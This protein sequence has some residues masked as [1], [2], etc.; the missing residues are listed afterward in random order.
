MALTSYTGLLASLAGWLMRDDLTAV[1]PDFVALAEANMNRR[2]RLRTMMKRTTTPM[3]EAY[4]L[5]PP[6]FLEMWRL[7][8]DGTELRYVSTALL[9]GYA[10]SY[11]GSVPLYYSIVGEN[12]QVAPAPAVSG[13]SLLELV[14]YAKPPA[15]SQAN[16]TNRILEVSPDIYLY[17]SLVASAPYLGDDA[18][19]QTWGTLYGAAIDAEMAADEAASVGASP[20]VIRGGAFD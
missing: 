2:L 19:L 3:D 1:L 15:L 13:S 9:A 5:L 7:T 8:L 18:R 17:G 10:E 14:Y 20:L 12:L 6:D 11:R 4:E 16:Q